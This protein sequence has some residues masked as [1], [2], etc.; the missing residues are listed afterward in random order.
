M[1]SKSNFAANIG[2]PAIVDKTSTMEEIPTNCAGQPGPRIL[3]LSCSYP[4]PAEPG[5]GIFIQRRLQHLA[6]LTELKVVA[7]FAVVQYANP[8]GQRVRMGKSHCPTFR[9]DGKVE[10]THPRWF[11]PLSGGALIPFCLFVQLVYRLA[12]MRKKF[13]FEIIDT[14]FGYPDGIA[15]WLLSLALRVPFTM[16]FRGNEPKH[17]L[18]GINRYCMRQAVRRASRVFT[19]SER[20]RRFAISM[21]AEPAKVKTIPNGIDTAL[22]FPRDRL[23]CRV[24]HGFALDRPVILSAGALVERKGHHRIIQALK[25]LAAEG[26]AVQLV[27]AGGPGREGHYEKKIRQVVSDLGLG[28]AVRF[29]GAVPPDVIAEV[30]SAADLL[31]LAS[32]NEG[33]PNVVHEAL[34]CGTPVVATDVGA[35]PEMLRSR[36]YGLVVPANDQPALQRALHEALQTNWDRAAISDWGRARSWQQVALEVLQQM[37]TVVSEGQIKGLRS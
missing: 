9:R 24:K 29:L 28:T 17:S 12:R 25:N 5:L 10:V 30:M 26:I 16:T 27:I 22:F 7:P 37:R 21:G 19:V 8:N 15:G 11:Y 33:W 3:S 18:H 1:V 36:H 20:L 4:N 34:A 6:A 2:D 14:H 31:C 23:E 32:T 13:P 35:V